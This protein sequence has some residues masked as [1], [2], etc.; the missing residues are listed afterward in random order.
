MMIDLQGRHQS[1]ITATIDSDG[2]TTVEHN[3]D[4]PG[5]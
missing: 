2:R 5:K 3:F 1:P 4:A